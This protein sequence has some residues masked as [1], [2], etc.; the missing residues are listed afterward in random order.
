M[1][2][3]IVLVPHPHVRTDAKILGGSPYVVGSRVPVRRLWTFHQRGASIPTLIKRYPKL[4]PGAILDS[5][6]FAYDNPEVIEADLT[7]EEALISSTGVRAKRLRA[8]KQ[9]EL[10]FTPAASGR[11]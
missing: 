7:R 6:A 8:S 4:S 9:I 1:S 5:L 2:L 10:P 3:P 11:R